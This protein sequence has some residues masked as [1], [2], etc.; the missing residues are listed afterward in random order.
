MPR[1]L[2]FL[3]LFFAA[4]TL[5]AQIRVDLKLKRLQYIAYEP[6]MATLQITNLAGRDVELRNARGQH[7]FGFEI[8]GAENQPIPPAAPESSEPVLKIAS[9]ET[10]TRNFNLTPAYPIHDLGTY[11]V[12]AN[13]YFADFDKYFYSRPR[14]FQVTEARP[15]WQRTVG[16]PAGTTGRGRVR[17]YSLLTN[18]FPNYTALYVRVEDKESGIV[19]ATYSLGRLMN[20][21]EPQP[22]IDRMN[23]LHVLHCAAPRTWTYSRVGLDGRLLRHETI[24]ETKSPPHLRRMSDGAIAVNAGKP[25]LP[26][27]AA[28]RDDTPKLSSRRADLPGDEQE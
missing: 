24:R 15:I 16:V 18:R 20:F 13:V 2:L 22:E 19:Y 11:H 25:D 28:A 9:G 14:V 23:Q 5:H 21:G 26:A 6:I 1:K 7:W 10:V 4:G 8:T 3:F 17:T 27:T 12:R